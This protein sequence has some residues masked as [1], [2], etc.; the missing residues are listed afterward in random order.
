M[1][2][3]RWS[4]T[5]IEVYRRITEKGKELTV[6]GELNKVSRIGLGDL[7]DGKLL[8]GGKVCCHQYWK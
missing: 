5:Q 4:G 2:V 8:E 6:L 3:T 7:A 1:T